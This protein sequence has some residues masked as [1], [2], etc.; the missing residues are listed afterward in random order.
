MLRILL[1]R[2]QQGHRTIGFPATP[3]T[4]PD[5]FR[6]APRINASKCPDGCRECVKA[7]PTDAIAP[8]GQGLALDLGK[9][10]FCTD[11]VTACPEGAIT[12]GTE[13][14]LAA[15]TRDDLVIREAVTKRAAALD[16]KMRRLF[17]RSLKLRQVSAWGCHFCGAYVNGFNTVWFYLPRF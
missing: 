9:C 6:G 7:C 8:D 13:W 5:R 17:G 2:W 16:D 4:L 11:C 3:P 1:A 15:R 12:Y 10:L 14:S